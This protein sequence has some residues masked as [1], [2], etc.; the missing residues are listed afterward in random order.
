[1]EFW[2]SALLSHL[3]TAGK[4]QRAG[5]GRGETPKGVAVAQGWLQAVCIQGQTAS[6]HCRSSSAGI[7]LCSGKWDLTDWRPRGTRVPS[8]LLGAQHLGQPVDKSPGPFSPR[9]IGQEQRTA[10]TFAV[11]KGKA[12]S[13]PSKECFPAKLC[14]S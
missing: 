8:H 10:H 1:M 5:Q 14:S 7:S 4:L 11:I 12:G 3:K 13:L 2:L 6:A 9:N